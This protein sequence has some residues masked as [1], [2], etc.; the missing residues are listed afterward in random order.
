MNLTPEELGRSKQK[1][2]LSFFNQ[3]ITFTVY[4]R[5]EGTERIFPHDLLPRVLPGADWDVIERGL[6]QRVTALNLFFKDLYHDR[7]ILHDGVIPAEAIYSC[8]HF[9]RQMTG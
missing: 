4:G 5:K 8:R 3:G 7:R 9:R 6:T 2:D 1:A